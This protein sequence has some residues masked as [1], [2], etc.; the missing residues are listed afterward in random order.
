MFT[1]LVACTA[2]ICRSPRAAFVLAQR[3][4]EAGDGE[5]FTVMSAGT[6]ARPGYAIC[7]HSALGITKSDDGARF[8]DGHAS[9]RISPQLIDTADLILVPDIENRTR[10]ALVSP[11]ARRRTFTMRE[12]DR[13]LGDLLSDGVGSLPDLAARMH[14]RRADMAAEAPARHWFSF[15]PRLEA[16]PLDI[17]DGH[18][19]GPR[20]HRRTLDE[21]TIRADSLGS[22]LV[23]F[24]TVRTG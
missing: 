13:I 17:P 4:S 11:L 2:N 7:S 23:R 24:P 15:R 6:L 22:R 19:L 18:N 10:I 3:L 20:Q 21:V 12:A 9:Q 1:I 5:Q 16:E 8:A 14:E